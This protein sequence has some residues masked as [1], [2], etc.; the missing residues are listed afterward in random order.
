[1][2]YIKCGLKHHQVFVKCEFNEHLDECEL[3]SPPIL[4]V[5]RHENG[6]FLDKKVDTSIPIIF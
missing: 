6:Y 3:N 4:I 5:Q 1:M 2:H